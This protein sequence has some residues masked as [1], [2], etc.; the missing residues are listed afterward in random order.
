[1]EET[2][3]WILGWVRTQ[4]GGQKG[5]WR[6]W[7]KKWGRNIRTKCWKK[8][9]KKVLLKCLVTKTF[10]H[11]TERA[12][13]VVNRWIFHQESWRKKLQISQVLVLLCVLNSAHFSYYQKCKRSALFK[14]CY[15]KPLPS[16]FSKFCYKTAASANTWV[17]PALW[18]P[19][20]LPWALRW[21][22]AQSNN[23]ACLIQCNRLSVS[24]QGKH[25]HR[26][27]LSILLPTGVCLMHSYKRLLACGGR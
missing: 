4:L 3:S 23:T 22:R 9:F 27:Q 17:C 1:M 8:Y 24:K 18:M 5:W 15:H 25:P 2:S 20:L 10:T 26:K 14:L 19:K 6:T 16:R 21:R 12:D 13:G 11:M 7:G